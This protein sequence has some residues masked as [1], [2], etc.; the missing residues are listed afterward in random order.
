MGQQLSPQALRGLA[1]EVAEK[2]ISFLSK[3][4]CSEL[5]EVVEGDTIRAD[6]AADK[7][8]L[9]AIREKLDRF[10]VVSEESGVTG[11]DGYVLVV[12][13]LD[14]SLNYEH[15]IRW[16]SVSVAVAP[17]GSTSLNEVVAGAIAPLWGEILSFAKGEGCFEGNRRVTP[18]TG[19]SRIL[20]TYVESLD[21][22]ARIASIFSAMPKVKVRS[23]GSAALEIAMVGLRR[24]TAYVDL[25]GKLR[26]VDA[27]AAVGFARECGARAV[28]ETGDDIN[29]TITEVKPLGSI[30]VAHDELPLILEAIR[31]S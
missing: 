6:L 17:P 3:M 7:M 28:D 12:D 2:A 16:S 26:N 22:A 5:T 25:R 19:E 23:L 24:G 4:W 27:A 29:V 11:N 15:C 10:M 20:Y 9:D 18:R 21:E 31:A 14:G 13:P 8:I 30:I 1:V